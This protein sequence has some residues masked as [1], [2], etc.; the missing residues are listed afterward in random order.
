MIGTFRRLLLIAD[1]PRARLWFSV[2]LG[3][4]AL[5]FGIGLMATAGYL[6]ARAAERPAILSLTVAIVAVRFFGLARPLMRYLE[7][8]A[9]HDL[10]FRV[11]ARLRVRF[12][13]QIEPLAPAGLEVYRRGDLLSRM[14]G[15]VD[16]L[17]NIWLRGVVPVL[18]G[19]VAAAISVGVA[20][21]ILPVAGLVL[22]GGLLL[23]AAVVSGLAARLAHVAGKRKA[24][25]LGDFSADLVELFRGAPELAVYGRQEDALARVRGAD[26]ELARYARRDSIVAGLSDGLA[27]LAAGVTVALV[28]ASAVAA[29]DAGNLDR[30]SIALLALLTLAS[31]EA[32]NSF[33]QAARELSA[34]LAAG[35]RILELIDRDPVVRDPA[36]PAC[37][38]R[39]AA[40][41]LDRVVARYS[42]DEPEVLSG[43]N[44]TLEPGRS[45]AL[46]GASGSGKTTIVNLLLRFLDPQAGRVKLDGKDLRDYRQHDVREI[47]AVAGQGSHVF[48]TT[49]REN[50]RL[51][52][53][54]ATDEEIKEALGKARVRDWVE[55]LP[56]GLDTMV[57]EEGTQLSGGERQR[58][59]LARALLAGSPVLIL[60]EPTSQLDAATA[61]ELIRDVLSAADGRSVLLVTHRPEGLDLVDEVVVLDEGRTSVLPAGGGILRTASS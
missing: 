24:G 5:V 6:I 27:I 60:D 38:P 42:S 9:S 56:D 53:P 19:V 10:A 16:A 21:A 45:I 30:V 14:V 20:L 25:A 15:D 47:F 51:A 44:L 48:S 54:G 43:A 31:F 3:A 33:P 23:T 50:V 28:L 8:L 34:T 17:Q 40:V 35:S 26:R 39:S 58:I 55:R 22:T 36:E 12:Y 18:A 4:L 11:L 37:P 59:V 57:G 46:V 61:S 2:L 13:G 7:R 32:V 41:E 1:A 49:I 29:H 52:R